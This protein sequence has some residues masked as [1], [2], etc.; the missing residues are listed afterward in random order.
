MKFLEK[1]KSV[2]N[3]DEKKREWGMVEKFNVK[4]KIINLSLT[5]EL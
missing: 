5:L 4:D 1:L 2:T 3:L